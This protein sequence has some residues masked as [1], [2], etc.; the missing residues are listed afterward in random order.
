MEWVR[1]AVSLFARPG[2]LP[3]EKESRWCI[4]VLSADPPANPVV[5]IL[6]GLRTIL[7]LL[8]GEGRGEVERCN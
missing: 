6:S 8:G 5:R 2:L 3:G 1:R 4:S 7:P